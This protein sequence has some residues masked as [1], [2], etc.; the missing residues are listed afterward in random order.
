MVSGKAKAFWFVL[1]AALMGAAARKLPAQTPDA[2]TPGAVIKVSVKLVQVDATVTD[3]K[4]HPVRD[5]RPEDFEILQDG[6]RQVITNFSYVNPPET[7]HSVARADVASGNSSKVR[8]QDIHRTIALVVDDLG[9]SFQSGVWV[10][11]ALKHYVD[12]ELQ[13]GDLVAVIRTGSGVGA[14]QQFT[15][16]RRILHAAIDRIRYNP[17]GGGAQGAFA[18]I[19]SHLTNV[20]DGANPSG[21][22]S[23]LVNPQDEWK[24]NF[25]AGAMG[26]VRYVVD[27]LRDLPGRKQVVLFSEN[28]QVF[29]RGEPS[30]RVVDALKKLVDAANRSAV[31]IYAIDPGGLRYTGLTAGDDTGRSNPQA[32]LS[33]ATTRSN[34]EYELRQGMRQL[35]DETGGLF[36][37]GRNDLEKELQEVID[38][39]AG[40]YVL[41]YHPEAK[42][43]DAKTGQ[44]RFHSLKVRVLRSGLQVRSRSG[45]LGVEDS[46]KPVSGGTPREQLLRA[47]VS[48]FS[49]GDVHLRLTALFNMDVQKGPVLDSMLYVDTHELHFTTMPDGGQ[50]ASFTAVAV[51]F[52]ENGVPADSSEQTFSLRAKDDAKYAELLRTGL[53]FVLQHP[54]KKPGPYQMRVAIRDES[55]GAI[56]SASQFIEVPDLHHGNLA[57]SSILL[58]PGEGLTGEGEPAKDASG[59]L[60][61]Y[62][63][64][65]RAFKP[66]QPVVYVYQILNAHA[67]ASKQTD[68][69]A[70]VR[71]FRNGE[72]IFSGVPAAPVMQDS[73]TLSRLVC[74]G[75]IQLGSKMSPGDYVLEVA[76]TDKLSKQRHAPVKQAIDFEVQ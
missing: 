50:Q 27:G 68:L 22:Q 52:D 12:T 29:F 71:L 6:K 25:I 26:A 61:P 44:P 10:R 17:M 4:G 11:T 37:Q 8:F 49:S 46:D 32:L 13:P 66:G 15:T 31:V 54:A 60:V 56:G 20:R 74:G 72:P 1:V 43:F 76:V 73:S 40:Y 47:L 30:E 28:T 34:D 23:P 67:N 5:L 45:F 33:A 16:D 35:T 55:S 59:Q 58:T 41:G 42:T 39:A 24:Q 70:Q 9:L 57:V 48:P 53:A 51:T 63:P 69:E 64:A 19:E 3:E 2:A 75:A 36:L 21:A 7:A 14:L 18:P 65:L 38:D 62:T